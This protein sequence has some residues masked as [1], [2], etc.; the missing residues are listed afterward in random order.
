[1][2]RRV[3]P[4]AGVRTPGRGVDRIMARPVSGESPVE[5]VTMKAGIKER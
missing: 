2:S 3:D 1:M 5:P 4:R